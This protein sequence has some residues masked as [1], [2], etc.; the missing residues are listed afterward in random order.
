M[1]TSKIYLINA[2]KTNSGS[3]DEGN[4]NAKPTKTRKPFRIAFAAIGLTSL[5][6]TI[7]SADEL[8][9][10]VAKVRIAT[11]RFNDVNVALAEGYVPDP[12]NHCVTAAGEGLPAEMGGMGIHYLRPDLLGLTAMTPR[13]DGTGTHTDF[14]NPAILL[15]EPQADG[16]L[17]L[18]GAENLVFKKAWEAAGNTE[19]P[20]FAGRHWDFMEDDPETPAD[21]AHGFEAHYDQHVYFRGD[22]VQAAIQPF[23]SAVSCEHHSGH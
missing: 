22:D 18:V 21:E 15:Y 19:P 12:A 13:V 4:M 23:H 2:T 9:E 7:A 6:V 1:P 16:S 8:T 20:V 11:E 3:A 10:A 5:F 14:D 17:V